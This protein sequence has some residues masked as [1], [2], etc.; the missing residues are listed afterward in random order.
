MRAYTPHTHTYIPSPTYTNPH[1]CRFYYW[2]QYKN[3]DKELVLSHCWGPPGYVIS[4]MI[5][6]LRSGTCGTAPGLE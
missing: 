2:K 1:R 5:P 6:F 3:E 4:V